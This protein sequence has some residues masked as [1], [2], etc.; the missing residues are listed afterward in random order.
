VPTGRQQLTAAVRLP[1]AA[2]DENTGPRS[3]AIGRFLHT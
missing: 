2:I 1:S 3:P